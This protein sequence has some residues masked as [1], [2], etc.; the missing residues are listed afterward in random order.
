MSDIVVLGS[1][2]MD[3]VTKTERLPEN[4]ETLV[5]TS[6]IQNAGG[7][8]ANQAATIAK[9]GK[10]VKFI[11]MVGNDD[12]GNEAKEVLNEVGVQTDY[13]EK[14]DLASTGIGNVMVGK[15]G[16]N[17]II[18]IPGANLKYSAKEFEKVKGLIKS[19]KLLVMQLEMD[20]KLTKI[21]LDFAHKNGVE[22]L[23][24]PAPARE[25]PMEL[26]KKVNYLTPNETELGILTKQVISTTDDA[27]AA[28][29]TLVEKGVDNVIVTLGE[30][31]AFWVDSNKNITKMKAFS[32]KA[33]D[34][35][36]AGDSFNGALA[37][38]IIDG[39]DKHEI[40]KT[41]NQVG[42]LTVTKTGAIQALPTYEELYEFQQALEVT[43]M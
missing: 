40:L 17:R 27:I 35:V 10:P 28:A 5:G 18:I 42:A 2:M 21:A 13:L 32:V 11:G 6:F 43:N 41:A 37:C 9:L 34:T 25:L 4:G 15:D 22:T 19:A 38:G 31:G 8:G 29:Q 36:A 30:N 1:F 33:I 14:S 26:L 23:L 39:L 24:N 20:F 16:S 12:F 3:L 7:K